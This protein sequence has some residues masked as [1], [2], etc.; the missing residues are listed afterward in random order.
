MTTVHVFR[1]LAGLAVLIFPTRG[2]VLPGSELGNRVTSQALMPS[3]GGEP[4]EYFEWRSV[5]FFILNH[6]EFGVLN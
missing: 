4:L 1:N 6:L 3:S 2:R 5:E